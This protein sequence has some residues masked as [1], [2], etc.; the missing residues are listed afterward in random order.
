[1]KRTKQAI[2]YAESNI[3]NAFK[4]GLTVYDSGYIR[5]FKRTIKAFKFRDGSYIGIVST[6]K[7]IK[8]FAYTSKK[9]FETSYFYRK[10][11][12]S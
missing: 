4:Y 10:F 5:E 8:T 7:E 1:M 9:S 11:V 6:S 12:K 3:L 2:K